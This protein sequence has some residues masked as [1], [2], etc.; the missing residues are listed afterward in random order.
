MNL[1]GKKQKLC[2]EW[3]AKPTWRFLKGTFYLIQIC[4]KSYQHAKAWRLPRSEDLPEMDY[5]PKPVRSHFKSLRC[6][7]SIA[8][9]RTVRTGF[10][11]RASGQI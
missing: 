5:N 3:D 10:W 9:L 4:R 6:F 7:A 1:Q 11:W 2:L 8:G